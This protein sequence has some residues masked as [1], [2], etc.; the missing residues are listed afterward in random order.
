MYFQVTDP[1]VDNPGCI[2][3]NEHP[4]L[5]CGGDS[6]TE[7]DFN[8]CTTSALRIVEELLKCVTISKH[9]KDTH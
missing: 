6:F 7:S 9:K 8:G 5:I 4:S 3:L 2:V 1:Y